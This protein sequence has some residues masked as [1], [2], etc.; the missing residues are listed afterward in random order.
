VEGLAVALTMAGGVVSTTV[1]AETQVAAFPAASRTVNVTGVLPSPTEVPAAGVC[2]TTSAEDGVQLSV[3]ATPFVRSGT[4]PW[5]V[6]SA[7]M[8][9]SGGQAV[10]T[11][12]VVSRTV[13]VEEQFV[14]FPAASTTENVTGVTPSPTDVPGAGDCETRSPAALVQLSV[15]VTPERMSGTTA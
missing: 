1:M 15:A 14:T 11:G 3:A 5:Q 8:T 4:T 10:I 7:D 12:G 6:L 9:L 2:T 13:S